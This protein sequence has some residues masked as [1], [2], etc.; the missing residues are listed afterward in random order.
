MHLKHGI[1]VLSQRK[2]SLTKGRGKWNP[3]GLSSGSITKKH[4]ISLTS[5]IK[6]KL[7]AEVR[8]AKALPE[9]GRMEADICLHGGVGGRDEIYGE[10][11]ESWQLSGFTY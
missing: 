5:S 8:K 10:G 11:R 6:E 1:C 3:F 2:L 7:S 4:V 9:W